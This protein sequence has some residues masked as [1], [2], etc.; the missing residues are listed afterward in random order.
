MKIFE[1]RGHP[2]TA[3]VASQI[4]KGIQEW[5]ENSKKNPE[6]FDAV[7]R[8]YLGKDYENHKGAVANVVSELTNTEEDLD[9]VVG[10]TLGESYYA[11]IRSSDDDITGEYNIQKVLAKEGIEIDG[12]MAKQ[13]IAALEYVHNLGRKDVVAEE[14]NNTDKA[15]SDVDK[16]KPDVEKSK[17]D[18]KDKVNDMDFSGLRTYKDVFKK[19]GIEGAGELL[20][21][22]NDK[23]AEES[24]L[25]RLTWKFTEA[26]FN[27]I[28]TIKSVKQRAYMRDI[29]EFFPNVSYN[30]L[31]A[32][33]Q[34]LKHVHNIKDD[35]KINIC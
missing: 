13:L 3:V 25:N 21:E 7:F 17:E 2:V 33:Q 22:L 11:Y 24:L 30:E 26:E 27:D 12:K 14:L 16:A 32:L 34:S 19:F 5:S 9:S 8:K 31:L 15:Q 4:S 35:S 23:K 1:K 10:N 20:S 29:K 18:K 28:H 6:T